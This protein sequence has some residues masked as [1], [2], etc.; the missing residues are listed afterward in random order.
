[1]RILLSFVIEIHHAVCFPNVAAF[2]HH[3]TSIRSAWGLYHSLQWNEATH[4]NRHAST[5]IAVADAKPLAQRLVH[6]DL[7][8]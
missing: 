8:V 6:C 1:M 2:Q 3:R 4:L 7:P 5:E